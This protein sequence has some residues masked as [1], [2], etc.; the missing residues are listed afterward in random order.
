MKK[1]SSLVIVES[2][3]KSTA[4]LGYSPKETGKVV[5]KTIKRHSHG[6]AKKGHGK[7]K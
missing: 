7:A 5:E 4:V 2:P 3:K 1:K 6:K